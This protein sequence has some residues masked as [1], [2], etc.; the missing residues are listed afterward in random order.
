MTVTV[1]EKKIDSTSV[2]IHNNSWCRF[3]AC[4]I[5]YCIDWQMSQPFHWSFSPSSLS[6]QLKSSCTENMGILHRKL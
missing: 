4:G 6:K 3:K 1:M 5:W 2:A